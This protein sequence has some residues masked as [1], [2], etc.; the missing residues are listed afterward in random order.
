M[1][2]LY[3]VTKDPEELQNLA[4][5]PRNKQELQR[6]KAKLKYWQKETYDIW[7]SKWDFE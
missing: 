2:E 6:M 3:D 1:F 4:S 7:V 5:D